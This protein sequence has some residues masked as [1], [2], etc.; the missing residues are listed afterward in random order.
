[1]LVDMHVGPY[2]DG[3]VVQLGGTDPE[4]LKVG[5]KAFATLGKAR[6]GWFSSGAWMSS[7]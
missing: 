3:V 5:A 7:L 2:D 1:M 6:I 4:E